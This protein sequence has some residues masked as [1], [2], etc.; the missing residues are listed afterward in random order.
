MVTQMVVDS[1]YSETSYMTAIGT[2]S[3]DL[4]DLTTVV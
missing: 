3:D 1:G 2:V 4:V